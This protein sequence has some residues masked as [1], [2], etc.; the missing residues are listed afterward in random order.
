MNNTYPF[1]GIGSSY[2]VGEDMYLKLL[3]IN[4][5]CQLSEDLHS[6]RV[7]AKNSTED[8]V[9]LIFSYSGETKEMIESL[10]LC[11]ENNTPTI[12]I[13]KY[14]KTPISNN[15]DYVLYVSAAEPLFRKGAIGSRI[16]QLNINDILYTG[17]VNREYDYSMKQLVSTHIEKESNK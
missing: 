8:D 7:M 5:P 13:T 16:A 9:A 6:Q 11:K 14:A 10:K 12:A 4:H 2:C 17:L 15:A 3:R 1:F